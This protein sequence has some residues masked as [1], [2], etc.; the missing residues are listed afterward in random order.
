MVVV[1][2]A[3]AAFAERNDELIPDTSAAAA[4]N[5]SGLATVNDIISIPFVRD[6][7]ALKRILQQSIWLTG[8]FS[9]LGRMADSTDEIPS[10]DW[11][12][13]ARLSISTNCLRTWFK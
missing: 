8:H 13:T 9:S 10:P 5:T 3:A 6:R 7:F 12:R 11:G 4:R 1:G 2:T